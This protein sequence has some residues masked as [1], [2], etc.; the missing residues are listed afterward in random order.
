MVTSAARQSYLAA[1]LPQV[2]RTS[3]KIPRSFPGGTLAGAVLVLALVMVMPAFTG[4]SSPAGNA[5]AAVPVALGLA[6][7][8]ASGA[9]P[10]PAT[11]FA[12]TQEI[13]GNISTQTPYAVAY[14]TQN[15]D[16]YTADYTSNNV[17]VINGASGKVL[18]NISVLAWIANP[19][20]VLY[21]PLNGDV[22]V[23]GSSANLTQD[24]ITIINPATNTVSGY[25]D[26]LGQAQ[27]WGMALDTQNGYLYVADSQAY[28]VSVI[29]GATNT[30]VTNIPVTGFSSSV[31][32]DSI[33]NM[34][35]VTNYTSTVFINPATESVVGGITWGTDIYTFHNT[36]WVVF[37]PVNGYLYISSS[38][39]DASASG[40]VYY[41]D[42]MVLNGANNSFVTEIPLY[43]QTDPLGMVYDPANQE[44]Y[45]AN[46]GQDNVT[47]INGT[48]ID[49]LV[50][51]DNVLGGAPMNVA[52]DSSNQNIYVANWFDGY[53]SIICTHPACQSSVQVSSLSVNQPVASVQVGTTLSITATPTCTGGACP[54]SITYAWTLN[55]S[56]G[57]VS[58]T[59]GATVTFTAGS[60]AGLTVVTVTATLGASHAQA[61]SNL[62]LT[63]TAVA[64]LVSV[65]VAPSSPTIAPNATQ[66]FVATATCSAG[67]CPAGGV[68]FAW[69]LN[70]SLGQI[71]ATTGSSVVFTAGAQLGQARLTV[72]ATL[73][74]SSAKSSVAFITISNS[75]SGNNNGN[76]NGGSSNGWLIWAIVGGVVGIAV[77]AGALVYVFKIRKPKTPAQNPAVYSAAPPAGS[78]PPPGSFPPPAAS[79]PPPPPPA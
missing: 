25:V 73:A 18:T 58:P 49:T 38:G 8:G 26:L 2:S 78:Y 43:S 67:G 71:S 12:S 68:H 64:S 35:Y 60:A 63:T 36:A 56:L 50:S 61:T 28:N 52:Y 54:S 21:D 31:A 32:Y 27:S 74:G 41:S 17:S 1:S 39:Y 13:I 29:N 57:S 79:P 77:V 65:S 11:P 16:L 75:G 20:N 47:V 6:P 62:T 9:A 23:S 70:G 69:V 5:P 48:S 42:V 44:I 3:P 46:S 14:D 72:T 30:L 10:S 37:D 19:T 76:G 59:T 51:L 7:S 66:T 22:Y 4:L 34:I 55:N 40:N 24:N 33:T 45:V 53:L 15:G